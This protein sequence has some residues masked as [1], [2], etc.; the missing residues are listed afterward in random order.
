MADRQGCVTLCWPNWVEVGALSGGNW[1]NQFPLSHLQDPVIQKVGRTVDAGLSSTQFSLTVTKSRPIG[2][3]ALINHNLTQTADW[4]VTMYF[5]EAQVDEAWTSGWVQVWPSVY[6]TSELEWEYDNF[7]FGTF[8]DDEV[9]S[10]T[11][12]A[13]QFVTDNSQVV[14]SVKVEINNTTNPDG[15]VK[16]GRVFISDVWQPRYSA[17]Y[18]IEYGFDIGTTFE[19]ADNPQM[20]EYADVKVPKRNVNFVLGSLNEE[21]GFRRALAI[22]RSQGLH[23]EILYTENT[24]PTVEG[25]QKTFIGRMVQPSALTHP[26]YMTF[27][28]SISL[29]E[30]L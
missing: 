1:N 6:S 15:F 18:G 14:R 2:V 29:K 7:W 8:D 17:Q 5:D 20:T 26:Y 11:H 28:N 10:F 27:Q 21:E 22:Q 3:V 19:T 24:I 16:I 25:F 12:L 4:K 13:T 9:A 23:G 30:I